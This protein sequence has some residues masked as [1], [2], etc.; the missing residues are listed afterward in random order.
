MLVF[1]SQT[2]LLDSSIWASI[3]GSLQSQY[4]FPNWKQLTAGKA[5]GNALQDIKM[6]VA[7]SRLRDSGEKEMR[8]TRGGWGETGHF[9]RHH[10]PVSQG[11]R[12][13]ML[14]RPH[15]LRKK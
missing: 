1:W 13:L 6:Y 14:I 2:K 11:A 4:L 3:Q 5:V 15:Y 9:S 8:K 10:R 12:V 7:C